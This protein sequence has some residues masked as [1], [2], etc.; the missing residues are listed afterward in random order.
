MRIA[1]PSN[2]NQWLKKWIQ[3]RPN[4]TA[5]DTQVSSPGIVP[6]KIKKRIKDEQK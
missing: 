1:E 2:C 3:I 4:I 6:L 5:K